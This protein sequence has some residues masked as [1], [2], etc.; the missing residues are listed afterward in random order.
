M[1]GM[2]PHRIRAVQKDYLA[3]V[4]STWTVTSWMK[5]LVV[6][7]LEVTHGQWLYRNI[8]VHDQVAGA[9]ASRKKEELRAAIEEVIGGKEDELAEEDKWLLEVNLDD[10]AVTSGEEQEYWLLAVKAALASR[11]LG[12]GGR[13]RCAR[14]H[15]GIR[16]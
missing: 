13:R 6:K 10:L 7:L 15:R 12:T 2:I 1:E 4:G 8:Q 16:A 9:L 11:A 14:T 5:G 3:V